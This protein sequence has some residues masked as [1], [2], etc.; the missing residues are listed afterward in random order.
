MDK[1]LEKIYNYIDGHMS[2][3]DMRLFQEELSSNASL[4]EMY[5]TQLHIHKTLS[6]VPAVAAPINLADNVMSMITEKKFSAE[7]YH[8]FSGLKNI[9]IGAIASLMMAIVLT[10]VFSNQTMPAYSIGTFGRYWD[11]LSEVISIP[12]GIYVYS[13]Y[14]CILLIIPFLIIADNYYRNRHKSSYTTS[15]N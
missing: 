6:Q 14:I 3:T 2:P 15:N 12:N 10:F 7:K 4:D 13:K 9:G 5:I 8:S 1:T 11:Q